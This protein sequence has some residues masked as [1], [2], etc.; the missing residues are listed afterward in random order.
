MTLTEPPARS[1]TALPALPSSMPPSLESE[2]RR[3]GSGA[4]GME[5]SSAP[6]EFYLQE[7]EK[8]FFFCTVGPSEGAND[9]RTESRNRTL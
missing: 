3:R 6:R 7:R 2:R 8:A 1:P 4:T 5:L 9:Y